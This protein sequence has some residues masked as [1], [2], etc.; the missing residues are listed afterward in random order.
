MGGWVGVCACA[1]SVPNFLF[2]FYY[3]LFQFSRI[4]KKEAEKQADFEIRTGTEWQTEF[5]AP[6]VCWFFSRA[7][8]FGKEPRAEEFFRSKSNYSG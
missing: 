6:F 1:C 3:L 4:K 2:H 5:N 8:V 7:V